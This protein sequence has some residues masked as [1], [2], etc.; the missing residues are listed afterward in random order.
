[1]KNTIEV[2]R[3][4]YRNRY[5]AKK[6]F[7]LNQLTNEEKL[8]VK[9]IQSK[10][11]KIIP[12][13]LSEEVVV[14]MR[15]KL[16]SIFDSYTDK[17]KIEIYNK[18]SNDKNLKTGI[19]TETGFKIWM[20]KNLSDN[21]IIH[22][23]L[24]SN[25]FADYFQ[26]KFILNVGSGFM[27]LKIKPKHA[28]ANKTVFVE[29]NLGSGGGWHRDNIYAFGFKGLVYL[30]DVTPENGPFQII[31]KS[32]S[33]NFHILKTNTPDKYQF[34]DN[35]IQN[36]ISTSDQIK[37]ITAKAGTLVLFDTNCIHR[38]KPITKGTRYALTNYYTEN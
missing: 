32:S 27:K 38:G 35:E 11:Y 10:S 12:N 9:E 19:T 21:R 5:V 25:L 22:A 30:N 6:D 14:S 16:D 13:F 36:Y 26:N 29:N 4:L 31:P 8:I 3:R 23:E 18:I 17:E 2:I 24:L 37:E 15:E 33:L 7:D 20:D 28:M 34:T 1:M